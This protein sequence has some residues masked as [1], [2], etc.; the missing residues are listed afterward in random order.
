MSHTALANLH[1]TRAIPNRGDSMRSR[2]ADINTDRLAF[3]EAAET[4]ATHDSVY[5]DAQPSHILDKEDNHTQPILARL[6][7]H[8]NLLR[9]APHLYSQT[10]E[11]YTVDV[12]T[13]GAWWR[14]TDPAKPPPLPPEQCPVQTGG[15]DTTSAFV[16]AA[17]A[18]AAWHHNTCGFATAAR[19]TV[20]VF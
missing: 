15:L 19:N 9:G 18:R 17:K 4:L 3:D 2:A 14:S 6:R 1:R 12:A 13:L 7:Q 10:P 5:L 16:T 11:R 8:R 20:S